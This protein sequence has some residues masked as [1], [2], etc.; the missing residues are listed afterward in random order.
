MTKQPPPMGASTPMKG[1]LVNDRI[2]RDPEKIKM[3]SEKNSAIHFEF[4]K[5]IPDMS[6]PKE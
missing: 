5:V 6:T 3:P 4:F 1:T 2:I